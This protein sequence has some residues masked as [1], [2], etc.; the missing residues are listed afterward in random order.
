MLLQTITCKNLEHTFLDLAA[1]FSISALARDCRRRK[2]P[3]YCLAFTNTGSSTA[4]EGS[5]TPACCIPINWRWTW[6]NQLLF[7]IKPEGYHWRLLVY[8]S[9]GWVD[10]PLVE[11]CYKMVEE[12]NAVNHME[13]RCFC[14]KDLDTGILVEP[15]QTERWEENTAD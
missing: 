11:C 15:T 3:W 7:R 13:Q 6:S 9:D 4:S 1:F 10:T 5:G 14:N 2:I 12:E 8:N